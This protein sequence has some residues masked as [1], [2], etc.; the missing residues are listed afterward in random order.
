MLRDLGF[1]FR[2][3]RRAP[4]MALTAA[5]TLALGIAATTALVSVVYAVLVNPLP[6][7]DS[8][9]L[10]QVW[11]SELPALTYGAASFP[12]YLDWRANQRPFSDLAAWAPRGMTLAGPEGPERV[13]GAT[14]SAAYFTVIGS[15]PLLGRWFTEDEDR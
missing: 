2:L 7:P 3:I 13:S 8:R 12:R 9:R 10:V 14:A 1:G 4:G 6:F 5:F 11:R 15:P